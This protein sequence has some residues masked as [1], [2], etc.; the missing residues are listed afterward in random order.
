VY[1]GA[2][3]QHTPQEQGDYL[4]N[5]EPR[6]LYRSRKQR[7]IAGICGGIGEYAKLDPT[8]VR[9][10][11][12]VL[13]VFSFSAFVIVYILIWIIIPEEPLAPPVPP[14]AGEAA[15]DQAKQ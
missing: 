15:S 13:A 3:Y 9:V 5:T 2:E 7:M 12:V 10:L 8:L 6:K 14:A 4:M 1:V 11:F